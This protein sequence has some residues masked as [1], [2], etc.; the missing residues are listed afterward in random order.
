MTLCMIWRSQ[1][2]IHFASDSRLSFGTSRCDAAIKVCRVPVTVLGVGGPD[3]PYPVY[4]TG[5]LGMTFAGSS[6]VALMMKEALAEVV[7]NVQGVSGYQDMGMRG[8]ADLMFR[9]F[10]VIARDIGSALGEV[11]A[12]AVLIAGYCKTSNS[13][14]AFRM[15]MDRNARHSLSEVLLNVGDFELLGNGADEARKLLP[16]H[17]QAPDFIKVLRLV[18][19]DSRVEGVG[20]SIQ[21]GEFRGQS[22]QPFGVAEI[23]KETRQVHHWRGPLDLNG[24]DFDS[25]AG[26]LPHFPY[27]DMLRFSSLPDGDEL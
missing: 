19:G 5:D 25:E 15:E 9:G 2:N 22:F 26:L 20:G 23:G 16:P 6:S 24:P 4:F 27:L 7:R 12:T 10:K 11:A 21:Y 17:P 18:I 3:E 1:T 8:I 14:R 13:L